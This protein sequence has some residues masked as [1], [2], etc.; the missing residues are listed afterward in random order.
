MN[1]GRARSTRSIVAIVGGAAAAAAVV[2]AGVIHGVAA[3]A[4]DPAADRQSIT[5]WSPAAGPAVGMVVETLGVPTTP[6]A[7]SY[8]STQR[9]GAGAPVTRISGSAGP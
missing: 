4:A 9:A 8:L 6:C 5:G 2:T 1:E 7:G 3:G